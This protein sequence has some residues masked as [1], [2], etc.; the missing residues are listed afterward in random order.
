LQEAVVGMKGTLTE[1][2]TRLST[3]VDDPSLSREVQDARQRCDDNTAEVL[4]LVLS[5]KA[6]ITSLQKEVSSVSERQETIQTSIKQLLDERRL[7]VSD[8]S[9]AG[10][11][12]IHT[13][14]KLEGRSNSTTEGVATAPGRSGSGSHS[15]DSG[16]A[17]L[18]ERA[19]QAFTT[20]HTPS[21]TP[22][23]QRASDQ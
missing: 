2:V 16:V 9:Q 20:D 5:L 14:S 11:I 1:A 18:L 13:R 19:H 21:P 23:N 7:L 17:L 10:V 4:K 6:D 8:L 12:S 3:V 22:T 15:N